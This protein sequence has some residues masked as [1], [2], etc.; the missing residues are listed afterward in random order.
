MAIGCGRANV[1]RAHHSGAPLWCGM[2]TNVAGAARFR[3]A[4]APDPLTMLSAASQ[5]RSSAVRK[6]PGAPHQAVYSSLFGV[7]EKGLFSVITPEVAFVLIALFT[8]E[9]SAV[10]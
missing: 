8:V 7:P 3:A 4:P 5:R 2:R 6:E 9:G 10:G 1:V